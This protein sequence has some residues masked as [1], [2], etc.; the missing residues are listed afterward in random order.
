MYLSR[1]T[2]IVLQTL[3]V[4]YYET[5]KEKTVILS[6]CLSLAIELIQ[7]V[8]PI[9][10][11]TELTD[12]LFNVIS[13]IISAAVCQFLLSKKAFKPAAQTLHK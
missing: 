11:Y 7:F 4:L 1:K 9:N 2:S 6:L 8:L 13:G 3:W 5:V 10:R 12:I